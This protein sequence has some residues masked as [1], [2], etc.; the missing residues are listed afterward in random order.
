MDPLEHAQAR[1]RVLLIAPSLDILGGQAVQAARLLRELRKEASLDIDFLPMN[2][3]LAGPFAALQKVKYVRT[4]FTVVWFLVKLASCLRHYDILHVFSAA[5]FSF[6]SAPMPAILLAKLCG[7]KVILNYRDGQAED[8]LRNWRSAIPV[9]RKADVTV[10]PSGFLVDVFARFG[11]EARSVFNIIDVDRF[12]YRERQRLRP[13]FF[14]NRILE[15][16]YNVGCILRAFAL[17][18]RHYPDAS[19]TIAHDGVCRPALEQ[20]A[21]ELALEN[22]RFIGSV[23]HDDMPA[24]YDA[25]DLY[26]TS[27][28]VDCMPGSLLE[29]FASGLPVVATRAGGI[30]YILTHEE[31][32][33]LVPCNDHEALAAAALRLLRDP[34]LVA[35]LTANAYRDVARYRWPQIR[36]AWMSIYR[37]LA[38][39]EAS[40]EGA[41]DRAFQA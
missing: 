26:L 22:T 2:P 18:Q 3:R 11:L 8:H 40:V 30:P 4:V 1:I 34:E 16:L 23:P 9:I 10:A 14:T 25:A 24:L 41:R 29:C 27:P 35:R 39:G 20:L 21:R 5:Y 6:W 31:T 38:Y 33:L 28:D 32:G 15:P 12:H 37:E 36:G 17:I 7:K 19:L 13:I